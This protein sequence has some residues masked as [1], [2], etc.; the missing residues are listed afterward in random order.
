M[1]NIEPGVR[2]QDLFQSVDLILGNGDRELC[3]VEGIPERVLGLI[4][5]EY[6]DTAAV[7]SAFV[8]PQSIVRS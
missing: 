2:E 8:T 3:P 4:T 7:S 6:R 5:K 1:E